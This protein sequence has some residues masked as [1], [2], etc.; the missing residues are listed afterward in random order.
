M[1]VRSNFFPLGAAL[2]E[3]SDE[4]VVREY[5]SAEVRVLREAGVARSPLSFDFL[6]DPNWSL[7]KMTRF[8]AAHSL[9]SGAYRCEIIRDPYS[10]RPRGLTFIELPA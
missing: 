1:S 8:L 10:K 2:Q 9:K 5:V 6:D 4:A 3:A 7:D